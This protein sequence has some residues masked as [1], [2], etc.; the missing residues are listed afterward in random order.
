MKTVHFARRSKIAAAGVAVAALA[1]TGVAGAA[2]T[3]TPSN[4]V[5][6]S[7]GI[8]QFG[9]TDG[10]MAGRPDQ[11]TYSKGFF[12]DPSV[13]S[14]ASSGCEAGEPFK[15]APP[16]HRNTLYITV[17]LGFTVPNQ[18]CPDKLA[19]VDHPGTIDL[20]R[21]APK[22]APLYKG[23]SMDKLKRMLLNAPVPGHDHF[24]TADDGGR[25]E[26]FDVQV[27]GVLD[28][29]VY[30][31]FAMS[32]DYAAIQRMLDAKDKRVLG[33]IPT[34]IFLFFGAH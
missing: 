29:G 33:P 26:P 31:Q 18:Q 23:V 20:T 9:K 7:H 28:R 4:A 16:G 8:D 6:S 27:I 17:P 19:C 22:L 10:G 3:T 12:C 11:L 15:K 2:S 5:R 32:H 1:A 30:D 34:N 21:L 13:S 24:I 14:G 25:T